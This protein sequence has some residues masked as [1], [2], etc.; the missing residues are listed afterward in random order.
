MV[1]LRTV[2][3]TSVATF[4]STS[5][6]AACPL[7]NEVSVPDGSQASEEEML[8]GQVAVKS[9]MAEMEDYLK[10]LEVE[11]E[12]AGDTQTKEELA[13]LKAQHDS[14]H[15]SAIDNMERVANNFNA[16]I[17]EYKKQNP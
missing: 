8:A 16:Q 6:F 4:S 3:L 1:K 13:A 5:A 17:R 9:W 10:C 14:E 12:P 2:M 15:N 11:Y 7:P